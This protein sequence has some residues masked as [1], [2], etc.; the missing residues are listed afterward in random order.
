MFPS[1]V[2]KWAVAERDDRTDIA[3]TASITEIIDDDRVET[4]SIKV[5]RPAPRA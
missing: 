4:K 5:T 1:E 3:P 2:S